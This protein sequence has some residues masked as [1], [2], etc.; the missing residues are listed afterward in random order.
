LFTDECFKYLFQ[1]PNSENYIVWGS[2]ECDVPPAYQLKQSAKV[3]VWGGMT[4]RGLKRLHIL[5]RGQ[6]LPS[7]DYIKEILEKEEKSLTS[8]RQVTGGPTERKLFS[9]KKAMTFVQDLC[10]YSMPCRLKNVRKNKGG[11]AADAGY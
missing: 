11:R 3:M 6:T 5:P 9:S 4:G 2:Q 1:Y 8:R 7:E 10:A